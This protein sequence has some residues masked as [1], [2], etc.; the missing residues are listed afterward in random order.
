MATSKG[1]SQFT[2][3]RFTCLFLSCGVHS[4][5]GTDEN[6]MDS[7]QSLRN[8]QLHMFFENCIIAIGY[9]MGQGYDWAIS[10]DHGTVLPYCNHA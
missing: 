9:N 2:F 8:L 10:L 1:F 4:H 6:L 5:K 7:I 3:L